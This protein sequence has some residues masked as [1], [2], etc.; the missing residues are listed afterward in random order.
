MPRAR[1][2]RQSKIERSSRVK[3][4]EGLFDLPATGASKLEWTVDLPLDSKEWQIG[5]IVGPSGCGKSTIARELWPAAM[6]DGF[7]WSPTAALVDGFPAEMKIKEITALLSSVGFSSPP[8]WLRPFR[9][10]SNGEQ[11]RATVARA[12]AENREL[13]VIDEFTSVVDRTVARIGSA[14]IA[15]TIR[16]RRAGRFVAVSCHDD[17]VDWLQPDWVFEPATGEF[18]WRSL[19]QRPTIQLEVHRCPRSYWRMFAHHHYLS[20]ELSPTADCWLGSVNGKP[21][22]FAANITRQHPAGTWRGEHRLVCLPDFQGVGIGNAMSEFVAS[23]YAGLGETYRS[24]SGHPAI[25]AHRTRSPLWE[26]QR[27]TSMAAVH[28]GRIGK[29]R[30]TITSSSGRLTASFRYVGP[31]L[32]RGLATELRRIDLSRALQARPNCTAPVLAR[33]AGVT[34]SMARKWLAQ[35]VAAGRVIASGSGRGVDRVGYKFASHQ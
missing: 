9:C 22:V 8:A 3:L 2:L 11:F 4:L 29:A 18:R 32:P 20:G 17:V 6:V 28:L 21:A 25:I 27:K 16:S 10:L 5:L 26:C 34:E 15:K 7:D 24:V 12:L 1:V 19:Q 31:R 23:V 13:C 33:E 14:A 30:K 35:A